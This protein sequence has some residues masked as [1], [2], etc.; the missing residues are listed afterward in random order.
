MKDSITNMVFLV[1]NMF[2]KKKKLQ[3]AD[4]SIYVVKSAEIIF[5][6]KDVK[7]ISSI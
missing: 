6:K 5:F 1:R 2:I 3:R 7:V 4:I